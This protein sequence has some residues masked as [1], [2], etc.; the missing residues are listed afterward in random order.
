MTTFASQEGK[1]TAGKTR[2]L[3]LEKKFLN[4]PVKNGVEKRLVSL[5]VDDNVV[6]E[7]EIELSPGES[8]CLEPYICHTFY[9]AEGKGSV[10][11]G[12]V[13]DVN[14]DQND[15]RFLEPVGR[16][17]VIVEDEAPLYLLCNEYPLAR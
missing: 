12:E 8:I 4:L 1:V 6:R 13:S 7:F 17:P 14:D 5:V 11:V 9:G 15:N 10:L 2:E 16:F 3:L